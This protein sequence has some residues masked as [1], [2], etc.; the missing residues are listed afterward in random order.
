MVRKV[1]MNTIK[2]GQIMMIPV[3]AMIMQKI[4]NAPTHQSLAVLQAPAVRASHL[5]RMRIKMTITTNKVK[6]MTTLQVLSHHL[7]V[8]Q[9]ALANHLAVKHQVLLLPRLLPRAPR[10]VPVTNER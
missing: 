9:L 10:L 8:V 7:P 2:L 1:K 4:I 3:R 5:L 6:K